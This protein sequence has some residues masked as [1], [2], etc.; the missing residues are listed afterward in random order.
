MPSKEGPRRKVGRFVCVVF[1][2]SFAC[3]LCF[4]CFWHGW[5]GLDVDGYGY[6][7]DMICTDKVEIRLWFTLWSEW[8]GYWPGFMGGGECRWGGVVG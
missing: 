2:F 7:Y 4:L 1:G 3:F 8:M 5:V 6:G